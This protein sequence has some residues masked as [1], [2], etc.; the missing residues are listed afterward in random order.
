MKYIKIIY[1]PVSGRGSAEDRVN[2]V[3]QILLNRGYTVNKYATK[4]QGDGRVQAINCQDG[5]WDLIIA[6]GGDGTINE[7]ASGIYESGSNIPLAILHEGTMND[8]AKHLGISNDPVEFCNMIDKFHFKSI[9]LGQSGDQYFLNVVAGGMITSVAHRTPSELKNMLGRVA[10]YLE[11]IKELTSSGLRSY[12]LRI[13][14]DDTSEEGRFNLFIISNSPTIGGFE[15]L[16]PLAHMQDGLLDCIFIREAGSIQEA[17]ELF[18]SVLKGEHI[19]HKKVLYFR[20]N[21]VDI[22]LVSGDDLEIDFDGE[23][24]GTLP[25]SIEI[26]PAAIKIL[27]KPD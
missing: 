26:I 9:D 6:A 22:D 3:A 25:I 10:Y 14:H 18:L 7:V 27:V 23:Y 19:N 24:A 11:V 4:K 16:M 12:K 15:Q 1:N 21:K 2:H 17:A 5:P 20:T 13:N 8:I